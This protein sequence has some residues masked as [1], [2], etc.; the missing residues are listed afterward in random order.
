MCTVHVCVC[1]TFLAVSVYSACMCLPHLPSCEC[2]QCMYVSASPSFDGLVPRPGGDSGASGERG[3]ISKLQEQLQSKAEAE[4]KLEKQRKVS[5]GRTA[6]LAL[7]PAA[8]IPSFCVATSVLHVP[9]ST[10]KAAT[11]QPRETWGQP[12]EAWGQPGEAWGQ[13]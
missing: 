11:L 8:G 9:A 3:E 4:E 5:V 1:L 7:F 6:R 13:D 12:G 2:V 10:S